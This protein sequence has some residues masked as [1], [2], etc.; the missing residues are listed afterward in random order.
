V[1]FE[2]VQQ[3]LLE[4][5]RRTVARYEMGGMSW[6]KLWWLVEIFNS[7]THSFSID[8]SFNFNSF[9]HGFANLYIH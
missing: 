3:K 5:L 2:E 8:H 6:V 4:L 1:T 7:F 9:S